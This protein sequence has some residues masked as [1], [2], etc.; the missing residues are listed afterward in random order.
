MQAIANECGREPDRPKLVA[1]I[2]RSQVWRDVGALKRELIEMWIGE[3]NAFTTS[4]SIV[5]AFGI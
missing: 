1:G 5:L 3:R 2:K 4:S